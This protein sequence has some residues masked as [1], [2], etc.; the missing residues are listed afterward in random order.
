M[1][2]TGKNRALTDRQAAF[3]REYL[4]DFRAAA[5]A[6]RAGY[7]AKDIDSVASNL[8]KVSQVA[9][10]VAAGQAKLEAKSE[11]S[12][13]RVLK[14]L[15]LLA[16]SDITHYVVDESGNVRLAPGAPEGALRALSS[17]KHKVRSYGEGERATVEHDVEIRLWNKP[18]PLKLA[19][20]HVGVKGFDEGRKLDIP[21]DATAVTFTLDLG[22][23][24]DG[25]SE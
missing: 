19:G 18:E 23:H 11:I 17:V 22:K 16:F 4:I 12:Q 9:A 1:A 5:A 6:R 14:E 20:R 15:E 25:D 10:A 8:L 21:E 13:V 2:R 7:R 3:V 24:G